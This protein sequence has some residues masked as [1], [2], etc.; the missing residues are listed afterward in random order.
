MEIA[1]AASEG[2]FLTML[3]IDEASQYY[4][5][6][7]DAYRQRFGGEPDVFTAYGYEGAKVL[8]QTIVEGG[9]I[10]EQ[11]ARM[12]AG[13]WPGLMGEVAFRQL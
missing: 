4:R 10:E 6:L 7:D 5:G 2:F 13:R 9:T 3:G 1:G 12:T 11:R 8:F